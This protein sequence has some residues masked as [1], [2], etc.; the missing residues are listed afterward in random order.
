MS[1]LIDEALKRFTENNLIDEALSFI[2]ENLS[3]KGTIFVGFSGGKDS[4]VTADLMKKSG[5]PY[6][7]YHSKTGIDAPEVVR[8]IK[9]NY[10]ECEIL[11]PKKTFWEL[12]MTR[13]PPGKTTRWCCDAL[14]KQPSDKLKLKHKVLGI[15]SEEST[16]RAKYTRFSERK[17]GNVHYYPILHWNEGEIWQ[18]IEDN[19]LAY[20]VLYDWGFSR[21]GCVICPFSSRKNS[22]DHA[23]HRKHWPRF[24]DLF[25]KKCR[26]WFE[27]RK[28]Q[29]K[30][31][32]YETADEFIAAW[33]EGKNNWYK[34][35]QRPD[36]GRTT[37][38]D[39]INS[40]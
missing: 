21:I 2:R 30:D 33:Y 34:Y 20:P 9:D 6:K 3:G 1:K 32:F 24:Y 36:D 12:I 38:D 17:S 22:R 16:R 28:A 15:R 39:F 25:E 5:V 7:L 19:N 26:Q 18:Y 27:K 4:I 10:P 11:K 8:F 14:K 37:F 13:N 35:K 29:G 23:F 40:K 31:M